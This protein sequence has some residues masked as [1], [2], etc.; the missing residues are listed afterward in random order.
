M[1]TLNDF[2]S[3]VNK[4]LAVTSYYLV[5]IS[6]PEGLVF[7]NI[8]GGTSTYNQDKLALFC[9]QANLPGLNIST[10]PTRIFGEVV[11]TPYEKI[12]HPVNLSFYIDIK[13]QVKAFF[14]AW[15]GIIQSETTRI[16]NYPQSYKTNI[17]IIIYDKNDNK[18]YVT[19]LYQAFPKSI[20]DIQLSYSGTEPMKLPVE[21]SYRYY[22][23]KTY[24]YTNDNNN[25]TD[26]L[27]NFIDFQSIFN[28]RSNSITE[29][30]IRDLWL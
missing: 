20:N 15:M 29:D 25:I 30:V 23:T 6:K 24:A 8:F 4:G 5:N 13:F 3:N 18:R 11:E 7:Q 28:K 1:A 17:S 9:E 19:T 26:Y 12:Y 14:D 21:I 10:I 16:H 22:K 2:I 27:N